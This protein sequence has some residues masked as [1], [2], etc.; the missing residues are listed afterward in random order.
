MEAAGVP[1][2]KVDRA[3]ERYHEIVVAPGWLVIT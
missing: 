1:I 3:R 2:G